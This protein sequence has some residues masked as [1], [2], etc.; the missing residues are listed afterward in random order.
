[1]KTIP[2]VCA[3]KS[4]NA[5]PKCG[6][7]LEINSLDGNGYDGAGADCDNCEM[8][9]VVT[10]WEDGTLGLT[11]CDEDEGVLWPDR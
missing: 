4:W 5:C 11:E 8:M 7:L 1:M 9:F 6:E 3:G 2:E 10:E